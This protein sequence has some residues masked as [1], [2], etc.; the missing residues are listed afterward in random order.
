MQSEFHILIREV[1]LTVMKC[2]K[3]FYT[4][5]RQLFHTDKTCQVNSSRDKGILQGAVPGLVLLFLGLQEAEGS[6]SQLP[7][8]CLSLCGDTHPILRS[9]H[10]QRRRPET[11][12]V[13]GHL[14]VV[15][16][17]EGSSCSSISPQGTLQG[18]LLHGPGQH[19]SWIQL[20]EQLQGFNSIIS[21][22]LKGIVEVS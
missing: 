20:P 3:K 7:G 2:K 22:I 17:R 15:L 8:Q 19:C 21:A 11:G 6:L 16:G 18:Q 13:R 9:P 5:K 4:N 1:D 12:H 10:D 14:L